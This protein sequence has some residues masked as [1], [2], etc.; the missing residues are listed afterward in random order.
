[1]ETLL[2][3]IKDE[4][5]QEERELSALEQVNKDEKAALERIEKAVAPAPATG[6]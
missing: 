5:I 3:Q 1:M 2:T 6:K 4:E